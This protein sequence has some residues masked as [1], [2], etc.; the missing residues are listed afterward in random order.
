MQINEKERSMLTLAVIACL[1]L[2]LAPFFPEPHIAGK[3]RWLMGGGHGMT[4]MDYFDLLF[5]GAPWIYLVYVLSKIFLKKS[6]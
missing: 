2:G 1:T 4:A 5:H 6:N 3:I